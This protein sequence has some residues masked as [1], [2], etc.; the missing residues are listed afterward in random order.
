MTGLHRISRLNDLKDG[1]LDPI[2]DRYGSI[3]VDEGLG[4]DLDSGDVATGS[5]RVI[6]RLQPYRNKETSGIDASLELIRGL[7]QVGGHFSFE[8]WHNED[9]QFVGT[10][11]RALAERFQEVVSVFFRN[12]H[13]T[14]RD[15]I[16]PD[17]HEGDSIA[18]ASVA[19]ENDHF[20][21]IRN[22]RGVT[23]MMRDPYEPIVAEMEALP[24]DVRILLQTVFVPAE[25]GWTSRVFV[26]ILSP[27]YDRLLGHDKGG[28]PFVPAEI[29]SGDLGEMI[30]DRSLVSEYLIE[31]DGDRAFLTAIRILAIAEDGGTASKSARRIAE[32]FTTGY[33]DPT[34][35]QGF[36]AKGVRRSRLRNFLQGAADRTF[37]TRRELIGKYKRKPMILTI[38]ELASVAHIP[39]TLEHDRFYF[40]APSIEWADTGAMEDPADDQDIPPDF[41]PD[42]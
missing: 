42:L 41:A 37:D 11:D 21:Q 39:S 26:P 28:I 19:L 35:S 13:V 22:F 1:V 7:Y 38:P 16:L 12:M 32:T 36:K 17:I 9:T 3:R 2:I 23:E 30:D 8:L 10:V 25:E 31:Q 34:M 5:D 15:E 20:L 18:G 4:A 33:D 40:D 27:I 29:T 24:D 6:F 14:E